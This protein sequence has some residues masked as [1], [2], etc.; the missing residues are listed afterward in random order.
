MGNFKMVKVIVGGLSLLVLSGC[1]AIK[2]DPY[3]ECTN[4]LS[5]APEAPL[6][7]TVG[8]AAGGLGL[9]L[10]GQ[11]SLEEIMIG[12]AAGATAGMVAAGG[13]QQHYV[14][15]KSLTETVEK[16]NK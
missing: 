8:A 3:T 9:A 13:M 16:Y 14:C 4:L 2:H 5:Y 6:Y 12:G 15:P 1:T 11:G 7:A 10:L